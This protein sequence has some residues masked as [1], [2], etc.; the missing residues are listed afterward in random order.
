MGQAVYGTR[1][2]EGNKPG[3]LEDAHC[4]GEGAAVISELVESMRY[5]VEGRHLK[6][7]EFQRKPIPTVPGM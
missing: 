5:A 3:C 2:S 4:P 7:W 1:S 6:M